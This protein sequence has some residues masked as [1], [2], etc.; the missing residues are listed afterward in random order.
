MHLTRAADI[1]DPTNT[2]DAAVHLRTVR[3][4][5]TLIELLV[6]ITIIAVLAA[7][8]LPAIKM[9]RE[10]AQSSKCRS[11][12]KMCGA[13]LYAWANDNESNLP[14]G[15]GKSP[16]WKAALLETND[17]LAM[18]CPSVRVQGGN[19]HYLAN[20]SAL[21]ANFGLDANTSNLR[22]SRVDDLRLNA[23]I[24]MDG[25]QQVGGQA[26]FTN[27]GMGFAFYYYDFS[28][29]VL[30]PDNNLPTPRLPNDED[31]VDNRH[32]GNRKANYLLG[33][34]SVQTLAPEAMTYG[35]F[36]HWSKGRRI[37]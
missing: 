8:L 12:L 19:R 23:V 15:E 30:R 16:D 2:A 17:S 33:D 34:G 18:T 3:T 31:K 26:R 36:R 29:G 37:Y 24:L 27:K 20:L 10:A 13:G 35:D 1:R 28:N 21:V 9:V 5:F 22:Q 32:S 11:N 4:A 25:G 7:M 14:W 6:V